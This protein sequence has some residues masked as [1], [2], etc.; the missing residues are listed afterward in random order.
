MTAKSTI[1]CGLAFVGAG[2]FQCSPL[3]NVC[4]NHCRSPLT[5]LLTE[6]RDGPTGAFLM[7]W[8]HGLFCTACCWL[9]MLLLFTVGVMNLLWI[10][11]LAIFA[12]SERVAP[13]RW[14]LAQVS[15]LVLFTFRPCILFLPP[16]AT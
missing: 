5:F 7:G 8:S 13:K 4:L 10:A 9:L 12:L 15:G 16:P 1:L 6:W 14:C 11:L 2:L 3:K